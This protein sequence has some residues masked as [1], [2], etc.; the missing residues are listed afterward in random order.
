MELNQTSMIP[1]SV[2]DP[3]TGTDIT[4]DVRLTA[5]EVGG[6]P[7]P[8]LKPNGDY[9]FTVIG[10]DETDL[11]EEV[12]FK[13]DVDWEGQ[14]FPLEAKTDITVKGTTASQLVVRIVGSFDGHERVL[15]TNGFMVQFQVSYHGRLLGAGEI[16]VNNTANT[17]AGL[18]I[19]YKGVL[20]DGVT[21]RMDVTGVELGDSKWFMVHVFRP[22]EPAKTVVLQGYADVVSASATDL[23]IW[24]EP[25]YR[26]INGVKG[27]KQIVF[28]KYYRGVN[29]V[30]YNAPGMSVRLAGN[31]AA[32]D[33][34]VKFI[35]ALPEGL[36]AQF[37]TAPSVKTSYII[38]VVMVY[39]GVTARSG[40][41]WYAHPGPANIPT[42]FAVS[43]KYPVLANSN[44]N[45]VWQV[46]ALNFPNIFDASNRPT[47]KGAVI[48][49]GV[50][51]SYDVVG[52]KELWREPF[53]NV[54]L[55]SL[56][57]F[58]TKHAV[59]YRRQTYNIGSVIIK[60]RFEAETPLWEKQWQYGRIVDWGVM[61]EEAPYTFKASSDAITGVTGRSP[62]IYI[63]ATQDRG[64]GSEVINGM[65]SAV[66]VTGAAS[67]KSLY[68]LE[69]NL[70]VL[71]MNARGLTGDVL[72]KGTF[73][74]ADTPAQVKTFEITIQA[75]SALD[76]NI[77]YQNLPAKV[78]DV[79][80]QFPMIIKSGATDVSANVV[81]FRIVDN[82]YVKSL[83]TEPYSWEITK[84]LTSSSLR[85]NTYFLFTLELDGQRYD[86][87]DFLD[88][89]IAQFTGK[90]FTS[91]ADYGEGLG[92]TTGIKVGQCIENGFTVYPVYK[93]KPKTDGISAVITTS[94]WFSNVP[95]RVHSLTE[96]GLGIN[97]VYD[98]PCTGTIGTT[99]PASVILTVDGTPGT[100]ADVDKWT[101]SFTLSIINGSGLYIANI[102]LTPSTQQLGKVLTWN[103]G[104]YLKAKRILP[105]DPGLKLEVKAAADALNLKIVGYS[106]Y[107]VYFAFINHIASATVIRNYLVGTHTLGGSSGNVPLNAQYNGSQGL[108]I[109][110]EALES[111]NGN[112]ENI[113]P[114]KFIRNNA[115]IGKPKTLY[116]VTGYGTPENGNALI[117]DIE[118][119]DDPSDTTRSALKFNSGWTGG[120][121]Y[122]ELV[123]D[124]NGLSDPWY[125][126]DAVIPVISAPIT[127]SQNSNKID[128]VDG[129][130]TE[131]G[132][133]LSQPRV[134]D[135]APISYNFATA[136]ITSTGIVTGAIKGAYEATNDNGNFSVVLHGNGKEG[137]GTV[138]LTVTDP[139]GFEYPIV[140][141]VEAAI[142]SS[143][144]VMSAI[145]PSS[146]TG[147]AGTATTMSG[148]TTYDG[149]TVLGWN[150]GSGN[151]HY[152]IE[153]EGWAEFTNPTKDN[154][155][156]KI[157]RNSD[158]D[159]SQEVFVVCNFLGMIA[160]QPVTVNVVKNMDTN[161]I[162]QN[163]EV[164]G[165]YTGYPFVVM[166]GEE[167][168]TATIL[169]AKPVN[170]NLVIPI[171]MENKNKPAVNM[172]TIKGVDYAND[173][174]RTEVVT[175]QYRLPTDAVDM[176]RTVDVVYNIAKYTGYSL[177][178]ATSKPY[179]T[180]VPFS[181]F[182]AD[183]FVYRYAE[184][185]TDRPINDG[186]INSSAL[187]ANSYTNFDGQGRY[188]FQVVN[189]AALIDT[190]GVSNTFSV[191]VGTGYIDGHNKLAINFIT[192]I[193]NPNNNSA[194][195][196]F[197]PNPLVGKL[198]EEIH[199]TVKVWRNGNPNELTQANLKDPVFT[200]TGIMEMVPG[201]RNN[202]GFLVRFIADIDVNS[203]ETE[204]TI[205]M[206]YATET[207]GSTKFIA[208][209][210]ATVL[211]LTQ[212]PGFQTTGSGDME[213]PVTLQQ[214]VLNPE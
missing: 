136:T 62:T 156:L 188:Q 73:T 26:S 135:S 88:Y 194:L 181:Q 98:A 92:V 124:F 45:F 63:T 37:L 162:V 126:R 197:Q 78:W 191:R 152:S 30:A 180:G 41:S 72:I 89:T 145:T 190:Y 22:E 133:T 60:T 57:Q 155:D 138:T 66:T 42:Q 210:M 109:T 81:D 112:T 179:Y 140:L 199:A 50:L 104:I 195:T 51:Y 164:W 97:Y 130:T 77:P 129:R 19:E 55:N 113:I 125:I 15:L 24:I 4:K 204:V 146:V 64:N 198:G 165:R 108:P 71:S 80:T 59:D 32:D 12:T 100:T 34:G 214:S 174:A 16:G 79:Y 17:N 48:E 56:Q 107:N 27:D 39:N 20:E 1:F 40:T 75:D 38:N 209:Q 160:K 65:F 185:I 33:A 119:I 83:D 99:V 102:S 105:T 69:G 31:V 157:T 94:G 76:I 28:C 82:D 171:K 116:S 148:E 29:P 161:A 90:T 58:V 176:V 122:P 23:R 118:L 95:C 206:P 13:L 91:T 182:Q 132:F 101:G 10:A 53:T 110:M 143:L 7:S 106:G 187:N 202:E 61:I 87:I 154:F 200:P 68:N 212:A 201:S 139:D 8:Y 175:W 67:Y 205:R 196:D 5:I 128:G 186:P 35:E 131:I 166:A 169:D 36:V 127:I 142:D 192:N 18:G 46:G 85:V 178:Y 121:V 153:P 211:K 25:R 144:L 49:S 14:P 103:S 189:N 177:T 54:P 207:G 150:N 74:T 208:K 158:V 114:V 52:A 134:E 44:E 203:K 137:P 168:I 147:K 193:Y 43:E 163:V 2:N 111:A 117:D 86:L 84:G 149:S 9:S 6:Q 70:G 159:I 47:S 3:I 123:L 170:D 141:N 96:D 93:G 120:N 213:N 151:V 11:T 183:F 21:H 115:D 172:W 184:P 167:D 173:P